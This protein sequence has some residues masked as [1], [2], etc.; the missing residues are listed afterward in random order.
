MVWLLDLDL[1]DCL[2]DNSIQHVSHEWNSENTSCFK[3]H[4]VVWVLYTLNLP[5]S[6]VPLDPHVHI[7]V[8]Y[9]TEREIK[10]KNE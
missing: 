1:Y 8:V 3:V 6:N 7:P 2:M 5:A 4:F 9:L 10:K